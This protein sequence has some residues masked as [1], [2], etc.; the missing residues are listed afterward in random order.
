MDRP[1]LHFR[2]PDPRRGSQLISWIRPI[3]IGMT[4]ILWIIGFSVTVLM[5]A[6]LA[7]ACLAALITRKHLSLTGWAMLITSSSTAW[8]MYG[9]LRAAIRYGDPTSDLR[10]GT[11]RNLGQK[12]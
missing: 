2:S 5:F 12:L 9:R 1:A 11:A 4:R 10:D 8:F 3:L 6:L 7:V